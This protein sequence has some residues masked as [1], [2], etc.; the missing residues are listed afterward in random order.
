MAQ[1]GETDINTGRDTGRDTARDT[2]QVPLSEVE[3]VSE[4]YV[5]KYAALDPTGATAV[6]IDDHPDSLTDYS[7]DALAERSDL[8][9]SALADLQRIETT[10]AK[11]PRDRIASAYMQE[12]LSVGLSLESLGEQ[13][14]ELNVLGGPI[15]ATR[16]V[17]DLM[18]RE[19]EQDWEQ[20]AKRLA[21]VSASLSSV[22]QTLESGIQQGLVAP[23]RQVEGVARQAAAWSGSTGN[24]S[25]FASLVEDFTRRGIGSKSLSDDLAKNSES[26]ATAFA[27][28]AEFLS[29]NY[30]PASTAVDGVGR[31]RYSVF[32]R[33][34]TGADLDL[35][36]A[37]EWGWAE[38]ARIEEQMTA[39]GAQIL[40]GA[41]ISEIV[42]LLE[43]DPA[44]SIEGPDA[45]RGW[46]QDLLDQTI[47]DLN[48]THFDIP[49]RVQRVEAMIA[50]PGGGA[51]MYYTGPSEDFSRPGRTWYPTQAHTRFPLWGEVS[52]CYHE[53]VPG[54]HLQIAQVVH[55]GAK[56]TRFQRTLGWNSGHGEGWAL[57]AERLMGELGYLEV[58][59]YEFGMLRAHAL[60][61]VR[62]IVDIGMHL[63]LRI[64]NTEKDFA[65][66][67]WTPEIGLAFAIKRSRFP[68]EM[69][70][71][72]ID[73]Y[74]GLPG[75]AIS[76]KIGE[77][78]W[79]EGRE[80]S[81][82]QLGADFNLKAWH[83]F[84][85][86]LGPLGLDLL[87]QELANF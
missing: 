43:T 44:R 24:Q 29:K 80:A 23:T 20:I 17:F 22:R 35:N 78:V 32:S 46:L 57:Y 21:G 53:G 85:L 59:D 65:G 41:G 64:P 51:A 16:E 86:D 81:K 9:R 2:G 61:A 49:E 39:V 70:A 45:F 67:V 30:L 5:S 12:R 71:F 18:A 63:G 14:R 76:Y 31:D 55:L 82:K 10:D 25:F 79:L 66:E 87:K 52:T 74:L 56:L 11:D 60:R 26:A 73:R 8:A 38:L 68:A 50:P 15:Q 62:V 34:Y 1:S 27:E 69:M 83:A 58:P 72:E 6:G 40:P 37:Y 77:R 84:A 75:Q 33:L 28:I 19:T 54:H 47:S 4:A 48:H 42:E 13:F 36:E 7:P 3:R